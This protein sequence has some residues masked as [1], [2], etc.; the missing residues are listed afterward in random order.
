LSL[1]LLFSFVHAL[2]AARGV[3]L[4]L[5]EAQIMKTNFPT[6]SGSA[7][8]TPMVYVRDKSVWQYKLLSRALPEA[9]SEDEL[10]TLGKDGWE[11]AAVLTSGG[12]AYFY[13]KRIK[14]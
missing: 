5:M 3:I 4:T 6:P 8:I 10:N 12:V 2:R 7:P 14:D 13:F 1:E 11:L 9:P